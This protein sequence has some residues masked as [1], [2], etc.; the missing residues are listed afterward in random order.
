MTGH[1]CEDWRFRSLYKRLDPE[2]MGVAV[3][4]STFHSVMKDWIA[5]CRQEGEE[6]ADLTNSI[7]DL[8]HDN[9]QLVVRNIKLQRTIETAEELNSRLSEEISDLKGKLK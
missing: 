7:N 1:S 4:F 8:Q 3:D 2:E 5:D 6:A 9:K